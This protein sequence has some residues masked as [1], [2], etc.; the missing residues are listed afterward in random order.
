MEEVTGILHEIVGVV[1]DALLMGKMYHTCS[2]TEYFCVQ[3][4]Q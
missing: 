4:K 3:M 2:S 1:D